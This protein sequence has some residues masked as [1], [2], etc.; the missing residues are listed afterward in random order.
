[1]DKGDAVIF[2]QP[3][4]S[5]KKI[6]AEWGEITHPITGKKTMHHGIDVATGAT[7][8]VAPRDGVVVAK[9]NWPKGRG[10]VL[11]LRHDNNIHTF[12]H[13]LYKEPRLEIGEFVKTGQPIARAGNTG[14]TTGGHLHFEVREGLD[15]KSSLNPL[16]YIVV[17]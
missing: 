1:M 4:T 12:Y 10:I 15:S 17:V 11:V 13:H 5:G 6:M 9:E 3:W 8:I 7:Q 14:R 2:Q 16:D